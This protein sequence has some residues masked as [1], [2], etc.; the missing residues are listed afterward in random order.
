[1]SDAPGAVLAVTA[2]SV[3]RP[4]VTSTVEVTVEPFCSFEGV[5]D[6]EDVTVH[7]TDGRTM[8]GHTAN[9]GVAFDQEDLPG[10]EWVMEKVVIGTGTTTEVLIGRPSGSVGEHG[11]HLKLSGSAGS[12]ALEHRPADSGGFIPI[13]SYAEFQLIRTAPGGLTGKYKQEAALDLLGKTGPGDFG[14]NPNDQEWTAIGDGTNKFTG[15]FDGDGK[16]ITNL[17]INKTGVANQGLFGY[18]GTNG[19]IEDVKILSGKVMGGNGTGGVVGR[20]DTASITGCTNN[21]TIVGSAQTGGVVGISGGSVTGCSNSGPVTGYGYTGGIVG[22][23]VSSVTACSNSGNIHGLGHRAGGIVGY[24][25]GYVTSCSNNGTVMADYEGTGGI[26]GYNTGYITSCSNDGT[27]MS[28][29]SSGYTG[30]IVGWTSTG[31]IIGCSNSGNVEGN[32][33]SG[34]V[35]GYV[36]DATVTACYNTGRV[37]GNDNVGGVAGRTY[38]AVT[39]CYNTGAVSGINSVGGVAGWNYVNNYTSGTIAACYNTGAVTA[40]TNIGG[41]VGDNVY[42]THPGTVTDSYWQSGRGASAGVDN[43]GASTVTNVESFSGAASFPNLSGN[44]NW[45]TGTGSGASQS[46]PIATTN[47]WWKPGTT[48]GGTLPKLWFEK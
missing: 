38:G 35:A 44:A 5:D 22:Y 19:V 48:N 37:S 15:T 45:G 27:V 10:G 4:E 17:Y 47:D 40:S 7:F 6:D 3:R 1:L 11:V 36:Q 39:A 21:G 32:Y 18:A 29:T 26:V 43:V 46:L 16:N 9:G 13:G 20:G 41:V 42:I 8:T 30:G 23:S 28:V 14:Q 25:T 24:N 31:S 12:Y 33:E 2:R 34:G